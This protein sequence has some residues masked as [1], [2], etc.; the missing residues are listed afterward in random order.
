M[1]VLRRILIGMVLALVLL[2]AGDYVS[3][4][5][6]IPGHRPAFDTIK[7][8]PYY[9]VPQ[10]NGKAEIMV[11]DPEMRTCVQ[12]L[13]PHLGAPPCW[14]LKRHTQVEIDL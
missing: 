14:Y 10:K 3:V 11:L 1:R 2:Y 8:Q 5:F 12:S 6:G 7:V 4:R 13:F 9:F